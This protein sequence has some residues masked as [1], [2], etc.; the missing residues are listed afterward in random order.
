MRVYNFLEKH[1]AIESLIYQRLKVSLFSD[2]NDPFEL[3]GVSLK[4]KSDRTD[5]YQLKKEV[6]EEMGAICFSK[7]WSSP[8]LWSHYSERHR[9]IVLGFDIPNE[10][11]HEVSYT[12]KIIEQELIEG[13]KSGDSDLSHMLLTTKY[14]HWAYEDEVRMLLKL[15]DT[16]QEDGKYFLPYCDALKLREVVI[17]PRCNLTKE[18]VLQIISG[19]NQKVKVTKSR[20]AF[21]SYRVI[22]DKRFK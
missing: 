20:L 22:T 16:T 1:W 6:S 5:F 11:A 12:G 2:M 15:T 3:L 19:K 10:H 8:V 4:T 18:H 7:S 21:Q 17:G 14:E 9:G 13:F